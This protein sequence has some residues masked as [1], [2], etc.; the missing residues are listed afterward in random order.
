MD[1]PIYTHK[2]CYIHWYT[3]FQPLSRGWYTCM[4]PHTAV[5][6]FKGW[7]LHWYNLFSPLKDGISTDTQ[8]CSNIRMVF[9]PPVAPAI[10]P[11]MTYYTGTRTVRMTCVTDLYSCTES[12]Y[13][14]SCRYNAVHCRLCHLYWNTAAQHCDGC[15]KQIYSSLALNGHWLVY[16]MSTA[17]YVN[18][19]ALNLFD[20]HFLAYLRTV[21]NVNSYYHHTKI[22]KKG[23]RV[24]CDV[25][26]YYSCTALYSFKYLS[27]L[28]STVTFKKLQQCV[29]HLLMSNSRPQ[30]RLVTSPDI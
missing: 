28:Y 5:Q 30:C 9:V 26:T 16:H 13:I 10:P 24:G 20:C 2:G 12:C 8:L 29:T 25:H 19:T 4:Y 7:Y 15:R 6:H 23:H 22:E 11:A 14:D 1:V 21:H 3:P 17:I 18:T 27:M